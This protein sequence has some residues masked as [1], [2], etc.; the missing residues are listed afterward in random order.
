MFRAVF[1]L[2]AATV[3]VYS[4]TGIG[5][6]SFLFYAAVDRDPAL[7]LAV[8]L[9]RLFSPFSVSVFFPPFR[10]RFVFCS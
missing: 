5:A 6:V 10:A 8:A 7:S 1:I 2:K 4:T 3:D 9:G